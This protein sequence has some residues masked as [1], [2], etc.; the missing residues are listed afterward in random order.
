MVALVRDRCYIRTKA[1]R[2]QQLG[3]VGYEAD[4]SHDQTV[5]ATRRMG[6][7]EQRRAPGADGDEKA[8]LAV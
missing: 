6:Q 1:E 8:V 2:E 4:D 5:G 7:G 3:G